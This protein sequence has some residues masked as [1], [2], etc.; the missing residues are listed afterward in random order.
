MAQEVLPAD[1]AGDRDYQR[2]CKEWEW[3]AADR[4]SLCKDFLQRYPDSRHT[5][6]VKALMASAYYADED[7][8]EAIALYEDVR[9]EYLADAERDRA[10]SEL[11]QAYLATGNHEAASRWYAVLA[12]VSTEAHD[13]AVYHLSYID[14]LDGHYSSALDRFRSLSDAPRYDEL[15]PYYIGEIHLRQGDPVQA[16]QV[17]ADYLNRYAGHK[18]DAEM[19]RILGEARYDQGY[20]PQSIAP[21]NEYRNGVSAPE[22]KALYKLGMSYYRTGVYSQAAET[23]SQV[24]GDTD[25]L[26]QNACL[27]MGLSYLE[28]KERNRAR[29]AFEQASNE[30]YDARVR[31]QALY[32]YALCVHETAYQPFAESVTVFERFLNEYPN[33]AYTEKVNDYLIDVYM[34]TRSYEAALQSIAKIKQP[35]ARI[36]EAKQRILYR[37]GTQSFANAD[38]PATVD[39]MTKSLAVGNYN[40]T[41]RA[42]ASLWR[43]E[44]YYRQGQY[45]EAEKDFRQSLSLAPD[46]STAEYGD[47]LYNLGYTAFTQQRYADAR[48]WFSRFTDRGSANTPTMQADAYNRIGDCLFENRAFDSARHYYEQALETDASQGDYALYQSAFVQGLQ[49][50]YTGKIETLNSLITR[51]QESPYVDDALYEQG[52]AFVQ[53]ENNAQAISRY[54]MLIKNFPES[55]LSRQAAQ[56][57]GLLYYQD[58]KYPEAISAYKQVMETYP[59][60]EEARGA[61][62]DLKA[63]YID[64]NKVDDYAAYVQSLPGGVQFDANERDSL[65]FVAAERVYM[66]GQTEEARNSFNRYLQ[67]FPYGSFATDAHYYIGVIDYNQQQYTSADTHLTKV[68]E[69]P[70]NRF[71]EEALRMSGYMAYTQKDY[72]KALTQYKRLRD[73]A[74]S[75]DVRTEARTGR[76]RSAGM[77]GDT[78]EIILSAGDLLTDAKATP[79]AQNEA[80]YYRAKAYAAAGQTQQA[81]ADWQLLAQ[82]TRHV[83]GAEAKFRLAET[84]YN[85][86]RKQEAEAVLLNYME[87][88]TPHTYWLARA[89]VLLADIYHDWGRDL[90]AR[91]Y[92]QSLQ[93][94]YTEKDDIQGMIQTRLSQWK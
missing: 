42:N 28:L 86:N 3:E 53:M 81:I 24:A 5:N 64:L 58:D 39:Y 13:E 63:I 26:G 15:V 94:N 2:V 73:L 88:S 51:Y 83:Y 16:E 17:A 59:G 32:N 85:L 55:A 93:Q 67:T 7:Y 44:A 80:L 90:D 46:A 37:L 34:N 52:R 62:R 36:L 23:L 22:H 8:D 84:Q 35:G 82:D 12:E 72:R 61:Q 6:R 50:D 1:A 65:T 92:L 78:D 47:A 75:Q 30:N 66:K 14:Y 20:Y 10:L 60:T 70:S 89:F 76:L 43:G 57:I 25:A 79:E 9:F 11:A 29:M 18:D 74:T 49:R 33:S 4:I 38:F 41:T 19:R 56:E 27:H 77:L 48:T 71:T 21:L 31:E 69:A 40:A 54:R 91:Q 68:L 87:V 45:A